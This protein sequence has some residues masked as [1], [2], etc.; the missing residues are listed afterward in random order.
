MRCGPGRDLQAAGAGLDDA[1]ALDL[2]GELCAAVVREPIR[3]HELAQQRQR[4]ASLRLARQLA[5]LDRDARGVGIVLEARTDDEAAARGARRQGR[6]ATPQASLR[7]GKVIP[8]ANRRPSGSRPVAAAAAPWPNQS[9]RPSTSS[10]A[11]TSPYSVRADQEPSGR[12]GSPRPSIAAGSSRP[13]VQVLR[14]EATRPG[15]ARS[16]PAVRRHRR[17]ACAGSR[18]AARA[19]RTSAG[20]AS[21]HAVRSLMSADGRRRPLEEERVLGVV[22]L[23]D[24]GRPSRRHQPGRKA[25]RRA[26]RARSA[27]RTAPPSSAP[28]RP[29]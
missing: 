16:G 21:R 5:R 27:R 9:S 20:D 24:R 2:A 11:G 17:R 7:R 26:T 29:R 1:A 3:R 28:G 4:G 10:P 6:R 23:L 13:L 18:S 12:S 19:G 8:H 15:R 14:L 25:V 22:E